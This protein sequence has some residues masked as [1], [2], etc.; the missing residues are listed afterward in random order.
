MLDDLNITHAIRCLI[1]PLRINSAFEA[2]DGEVED[3]A[4]LLAEIVDSLIE[5]LIHV[6]NDIYI[7][8]RTETKD[9]TVKEIEERLREWGDGLS[10]IDSWFEPD[11]D[12]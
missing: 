4:L 9:E 12:N 6:R 2:L 7:N 3:N 11:E 1:R 10:D 5:E 8:S